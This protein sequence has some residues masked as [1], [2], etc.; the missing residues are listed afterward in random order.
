MDQRRKGGQGEGLEMAVRV[1]EVSIPREY[2][3]G[4]GQ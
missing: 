4:L 2:P 1:C 3:L